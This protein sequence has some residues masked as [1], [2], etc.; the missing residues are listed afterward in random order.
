M[1][2]TEALLIGCPVAG[3]FL[4]SIGLFAAWVRH[5]SRA[6]AP[7]L[8]VKVLT[9][10]RVLLP[11]IAS[12]LAGYAMFS[13]FFLV[14][15][16]VQAPKHL[17][18]QVAKHVHYGF[19]AGIADVGLYLLPVGVGLMCAGPSGGLIARRYGGKWPFAFGLAAMALASALLALAHDDAYLIAVWLFL[20]G[21]GFGLSVGAG[22]LFVTQA[23]DINKT[24]I[25]NAFLSLMRLIAGGIGAQIVAALLSSETI[26]GGGAPRESAFAIAFGLS[27]F[28]ALVGCGITLLVPVDKPKETTT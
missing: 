28:L 6:R 5:E 8:D 11:N 23:V 15:R 4:V 22:S 7:L 10:A 14:P 2:L 17:P 18:E 12:A 25:A 1:G 13:A 16:F 3:I 27:A 21:G 24:G 26:A 19:G 20:L 9:G